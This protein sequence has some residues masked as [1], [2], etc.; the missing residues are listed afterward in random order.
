MEL[1]KV[2]QCWIFIVLNRII[3]YLTVFN[4]PERTLYDKYNMIWL[5]LIHNKNQTF[6]FINLVLD[7]TNSY[8]KFLP[9]V[10]YN[11]TILTLTLTLTLTLSLS[12]A[13]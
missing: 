6:V 13:L 9:D 5:H 2:L 8:P 10:F 4:E 1:D 11:H 3:P 12:L 7:E